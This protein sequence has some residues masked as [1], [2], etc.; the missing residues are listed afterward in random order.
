MDIAEFLE[1]RWA[2]REAAAKAATPGP[3][4]WEA[5]GEKD[6]SWA[7]GFVQD[8]DGNTISL[9]DAER[10]WRR[11]KAALHGNKGPLFSYFIST[12]M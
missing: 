5:T 8:E 7:V 11:R 6:S 3:W 9:E 1:A 4:A 12:R 2:E 10:D